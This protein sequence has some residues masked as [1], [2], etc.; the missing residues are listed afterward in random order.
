MCSD[1][2]QSVRGCCGHPSD[3]PATQHST[4]RSPN[5]QVKTGLRPMSR[6]KT[7][8]LSR[9]IAN[10]G[11]LIETRLH[12]ETRPFRSV[13]GSFWSLSNFRVRERAIQRFVVLQ[14]PRAQRLVAVECARLSRVAIRDLK[15]N[16]NVHRQFLPVPVWRV[17]RSICSGA[18]RVIRTMTESS[19]KQQFRSGRP[20]CGS[21]RRSVALA[22]NGLHHADRFAGNPLRSV[23]GD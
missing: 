20:C 2:V 11:N 16:G 15:N 13:A 23:S 8:R 12:P 1:K 7:F 5:P 4:T 10:R 17:G 9:P 19:R 14:I 22:A 21:I 3:S 18:F 6:T